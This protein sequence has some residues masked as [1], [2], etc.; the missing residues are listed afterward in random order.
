MDHVQD[1]RGQPRLE[2]QLTHTQHRQR[3]LFR[4]LQH[5]SAP[6]GERGRKLPGGHQEGKIPG[7]DLPNNADGFP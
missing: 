7:D 3:S 4:G 6:R 2:H 5:H 1:A